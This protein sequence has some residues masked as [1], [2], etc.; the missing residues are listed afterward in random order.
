MARLARIV[1]V[2]VPHHVIQRGNRRQP[3]FFGEADYEAY[4]R[5][6]AEWCG[7]CGVAIWSY[8]LMPNHTHLIAVPAAADS[9]RLG[10][11]EAHRRYTRRINF[12]QEWRGHLWQERFRSY[13][14]D[15]RHL[16]AAARYIELN[17]VR[18][19]LAKR[20]ADYRWSSARAHVAKRDDGLVIVRPLLELVS[21]WAA[22]LASAEDD[23]AV[24][25]LR[26]SEGT[27]RPA[28]DAAF[29]RKLGRRLKRSLERQRPGPKPA[30]NGGKEK[31]DRGRKG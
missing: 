18:A 17:P 5:L 19:G 15:A 10:I 14:L 7:R 2:G 28:G 3:V 22:F 21:D 9:L 24:R 1:A 11:G 16:L 20:A 6:M 12:R 31:R 23:E 4:L 26:A 13:P 29:V 27:G 25:T 30:G 8:C